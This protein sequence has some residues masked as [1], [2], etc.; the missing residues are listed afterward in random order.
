MKEVQVS[1][2]E[3]KTKMVTKIVDVPVPEP[4]EGQL[5]IKVVVSGTNPKDWKI[6]VWVP[7]MMPMN[8]GDDIAGYV[9][10]IGSGV[11]DFKVG[12]RVA[13]FHEMM[14]PH[15]SFAEYAIAWEKS[16]FHIPEKTSFEEAATIP[17]AAMTAAV[18]LV[19]CFHIFQVLRAS[20]IY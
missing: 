13:A 12:D 11:T 9:E 16:T 8:T 20:S 18:G 19:S 17:L 10:K 4:A 5:L 3:E 2:N 1:A 15:G 6:P 14:K 7:Q